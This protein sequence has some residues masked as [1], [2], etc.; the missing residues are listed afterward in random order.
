MS[1]DPFLSVREDVE[2]NIEQAKQLIESYQ[3]IIKTS[4]SDSA[5]VVQT[6]EDIDAMFE[7]LDADIVDL[8]QSVNVISQDP[9]KYGVTIKEVEKRRGF[10]SNI[11]GDAAKLRSLAHPT[12]SE[13]P[14]KS[15][16]DAVADRVQ[17]EEDREQEE[18]Y[19]QQLMDDQD[20][21][22]DSVFHTVGNLR[23]QA[24]TMGQELG[25]QAEML[26][27]FEMAV[28]KS[29]N[30]L[31]RGMKQI[32]VFLKKNEDSRSNC[33]IGVLIFVLIILLVLVILL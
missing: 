4:S 5:E 20:E 6:L 11:E 9:E 27:E 19:Q 14:F 8:R 30:R 2:A 3:R 13:N 7:E 23:L 32:Q 10:L 18:L 24:N 16:E 22:L 12:S 29:A 26:E 28:D 31:K 17:T 21:Q 33:C 1:T 15:N 25:E